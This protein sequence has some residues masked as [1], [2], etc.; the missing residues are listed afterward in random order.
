MPDVSVSA[1]SVFAE[2][3]SIALLPLYLGCSFPV[4]RTQCN[5]SSE[6]DGSKIFPFLFWLLLYFMMLL[7][8][9]VSP[10]RAQRTSMAMLGVGLVL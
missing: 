5:G 6:V 3:A 8:L 7:L 2:S 4:M 9:I 1:V 10:A